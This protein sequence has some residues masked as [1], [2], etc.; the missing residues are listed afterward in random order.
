MRPDNHQSTHHN[1]QAS[2]TDG[3]MWVGSTSGSLPPVPPY[4]RSVR[5]SDVLV[6]EHCGLVTCA[7]IQ[8]HLSLEI[9]GHNSLCHIILY[10]TRMYIIFPEYYMVHYYTMKG[11]SWSL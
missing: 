2:W 7:I 11:E 9:K 6:Y 8:E 1:L 4:V 3:G 10:G 5:G